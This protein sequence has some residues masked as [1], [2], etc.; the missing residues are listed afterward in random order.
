MATEI[1]GLNQLLA[2]LQ[3]LPVDVEAAMTKALKDGSKTIVKAAQ[4]QVPVDTGNL[5][6]HIRAV[7]NKTPDDGA[8]IEIDVGVGKGA[9]YWRFIEFGHNVGKKNKHK[10]EAHPF[11]RPAFDNHHQDIGDSIKNALQKAINKAGN[12][13]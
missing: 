2:K 6:K 9:F 11:L 12:G 7:N 10:V 3:K 1:E 8:D 13:Q 5:K 4:A